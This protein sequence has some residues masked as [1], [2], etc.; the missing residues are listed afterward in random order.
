VWNLRSNA[1]RPASWT[2]ADAAGLPILP[3]LLNFAQIQQA[4]RTGRPITHAIRFTT[5]LLGRQGGPL[6]D[7]LTLAVLGRPGVRRGH[8]RPVTARPR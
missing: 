8:D 1:L 6:P 4:V 2:S 3:G 5:V 7:R